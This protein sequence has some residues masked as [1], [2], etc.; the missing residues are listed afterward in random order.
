Q[1]PNPVNNAVSD[2]DTVNASASSLPLVIFGGWGNDS[3]TGGSGNDVILSDFGRVQYVDP[4]TGQIIASLGAGGHGD[5]TSSQIVDPTWIYSR[6]LTL[7]GNDTVQG[8]AGQDI[9]V[10]GAAND[11]ID[12]GTA[13]DL[14]F[15][16]A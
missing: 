9:L 1:S 12:G 14:I 8:G 16:D 10:G 4:A 3:I 5:S 6:D 2:D 13:D 15:G 7:G 11:M